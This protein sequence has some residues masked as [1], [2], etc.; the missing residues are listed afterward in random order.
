[1][2]GGTCKKPQEEKYDLPIV[3]PTETLIRYPDGLPFHPFLDA[4]LC[5]PARPKPENYLHTL[6]NRSN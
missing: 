1:M 3:H 4:W 6:R 5:Q 2:K